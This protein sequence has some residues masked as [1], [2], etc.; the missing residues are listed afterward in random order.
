VPLFQ[1]LWGLVCTVLGSDRREL[2]LS[3]STSGLGLY[4]PLSGLCFWCSDS[5]QPLWGLVCTFGEIFKMFQCRFQPLWGL[6]CTRGVRG[7]AVSVE[8]VS[9]PLGFG[10]YV[11]YVRRSVRDRFVSTLWVLVCTASWLLNAS[12]SSMFQP[13]WGLICTLPFCIFE[14]CF[15]PLGVLFVLATKVGSPLNCSNNFQPQRVWFVPAIR[16]GKVQGA[17]STPL[18]QPLW[19]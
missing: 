11:R 15:N 2:L 4:A 10:L 5:F 3:V 18:F 17:I 8:L 12:L 16:S 1:P 14:C 6:V 7:D 9:T 13:L 19:G